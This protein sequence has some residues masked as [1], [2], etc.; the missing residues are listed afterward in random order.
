MQHYYLNCAGKHD[1]S[2]IRRP[3][4]NFLGNQESIFFET[5][6][7]DYLLTY[8]TKNECSVIRSKIKSFFCF[9]SEAFK[10]QPLQNLP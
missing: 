3:M 2:I 9:I 7:T 5:F 1:L 6:I 4:N 10:Y 8:E